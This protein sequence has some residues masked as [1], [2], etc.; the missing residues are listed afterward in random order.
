MKPYIKAL[1][2]GLFLLLP[3]ASGAVVVIDPGHGGYDNGLVHITSTGKEIKEKDVA[4]QISLDLLTDLRARGGHGRLTREVDRNMSIS[5][6]IAAAGSKPVTAF[7]SL[8]LSDN[9]SFNIYIWNKPAQSGDL[10]SMYLLSNIQALH[11]DG[12]AVL[13]QAVQQA[14]KGAFPDR[15]V[16]IYQMDLPVLGGIDGPAAMVESPSAADINYEDPGNAARIA[17]ALAN[18]VM[19]AAVGPS[20]PNPSV[21]AP[22]PSGPVKNSPAPPSGR[23]IPNMPETH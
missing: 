13:A 4:L 16:A 1:V 9:G 10:K 22:G 5:E 17:G 19:A 12:S 11:V 7:L 20:A 6:R 2:F 3:A 14:L 23:I 8:H 18:A 21:P 15:Q